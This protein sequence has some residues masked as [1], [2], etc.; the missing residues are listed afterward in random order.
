VSALAGGCDG[1]L[2]IGTG[3]QWDN[4]GSGL[5]VRAAGTDVHT[6][7]ADRL[8]R[9]VYPQVASANTNAI[10]ADCARRRVWVGHMHHVNT[11]E[12]G[13]PI[14]QWAGGGLSR[15]DLGAAS[16]ARFGSQDGLETFAAAGIRGEVASVAVDAAG[17][18]WAGAFGTTSMDAGAL[19]ATRPY[20]PAVLN[21]FY[22]SA[23]ENWTFDRSGVVSS[24]ALDRGGRVWAATSR[25]GMTRDSVSPDN[26]PTGDAVGGL[27]VGTGTQWA[28]FTSRDD[29]LPSN[30]VSVVREAPDG[31]IWIGT[32]G[33]GMA[34]FEP[35]APPRT[36]TPTRNLP[37]RTPSPTRDPN[38]PTS[39]RPPT[40]LPTLPTQ[41]P[42]PTRPAT[43][44]LPRPGVDQSYFPWA[45]THGHGPPR[46]PLE[47]H[48]YLPWTV[49][50]R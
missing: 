15:W 5:T 26:W 16:W 45:H 28:R 32:L 44:T 43:A 30:D 24:V 35:G 14:G 4:V 12:T 37:T 21:R 46:P 29:G 11:A 8:T 2:W 40:R 20:W 38:E 50:A 7:A 1:E 3:N 6:P 39:T 36:A 17:A 42:S 31:T 49:K 10:A 41:V 23:W 22:G 13:G 9:H 48:V 27:M 34:R 47:E 19:V 25:H 18:V 33:W